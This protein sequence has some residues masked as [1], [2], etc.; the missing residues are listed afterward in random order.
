MYA[1]SLDKYRTAHS[2]MRVPFGRSETISRDITFN[3]FKVPTKSLEAYANKT[4]RL[5]IFCYY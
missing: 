2:C 3:S 5:V 4:E 1:C